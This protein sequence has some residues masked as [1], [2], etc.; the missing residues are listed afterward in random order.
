M[1]H[2]ATQRH[3]EKSMESSQESV[4]NIESPTQF[5][6]VMEPAGLPETFALDPS[7][8]TLMVRLSLLKQNTLCF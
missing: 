7:E 6:S 2:H 8:S 4:L 5:S 1:P 3:E